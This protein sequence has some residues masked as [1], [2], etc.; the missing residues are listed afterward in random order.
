MQ[1]T[2]GVPPDIAR[3]FYLSEEDTIIEGNGFGVL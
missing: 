2:L 3:D 1:K